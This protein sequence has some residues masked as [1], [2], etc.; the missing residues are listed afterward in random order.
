MSKPDKPGE[1]RNVDVQAISVVSRAANG[2]KFKVFKSAKEE[3]EA[4]APEVVE[5]D[6]RGLFRILKEFFTGEKVEKGAVADILNAQDSG[7][8]LGMAMDALFKVLGL[9]R[10]GEDAKDVETNPAKIRSALDDFKTVAEKILTGKDDDVKKAV[11][12]L[13]K[14]GRKIAGNRLAKLKNAQAILNEALSGLEDSEDTPKEAE[15]LT[16]E[17]IQKTV[18]EAVGKINIEEALQK[19]LAPVFERI[20]KARGISNR[21][22]EDSTVEKSTTD[23]WGGIF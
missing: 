1:L 5:K 13:Q 3:S 16:K 2:E 4:P 10:W 21:V 14:S 18:D 20:E 6:E 12:E 15:E 9:N 7:R 19:A 11:S 23:F 8:R 22:P 17:E